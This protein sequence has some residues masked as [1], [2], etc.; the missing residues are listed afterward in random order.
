LEKRKLIQEIIFMKKPRE[1]H[2]SRLIYA[3]PVQVARDLISPADAGETTF[4]LRTMRLKLLLVLRIVRFSAQPL[5]LRP[6]FPP[7][8]PGVI[9]TLAV[10]K[11]RALTGMAAPEVTVEVHLANGLPTFTMVDNNM[12]VFF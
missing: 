5:A 10:L 1:T 3:S 4:Q 12:P 7:S 9:M 8:S 6:G 11:S 2:D